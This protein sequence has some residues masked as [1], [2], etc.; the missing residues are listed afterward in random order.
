MDNP[1]NKIAETNSDE[2]LNPFAVTARFKAKVTQTIGVFASN[3]KEASEIADGFFDKTV[4]ED[5]E[6]VSAMPLDDYEAMMK[7]GEG[8]DKLSVN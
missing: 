4:V 6:I 2:S 8:S 5:F 1:E 3:E 7:I